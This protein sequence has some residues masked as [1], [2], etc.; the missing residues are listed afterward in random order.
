MGDE[1]QDFYQLA[2]EVAKEAGEVIKIVKF[3]ARL[4]DWIKAKERYRYR[5]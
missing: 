2:V 3:S 4:F 5:A 1:I